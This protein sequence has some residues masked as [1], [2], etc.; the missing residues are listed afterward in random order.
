LHDFFKIKSAFESVRISEKQRQHGPTPLNCLVWPFGDFLEL[1]IFLEKVK[2]LPSFDVS[3][4]TLFAS[5][6]QDAI[7]KCFPDDK[8]KY[9]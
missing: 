7:I 5:S 9:S 8:A 1:S 6:L 4:S 2:N 3:R